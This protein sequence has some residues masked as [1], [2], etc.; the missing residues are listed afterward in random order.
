MAA[1]TPTGVKAGGGR[2][3]SRSLVASGAHSAG[4]AIS[5]Q[6]KVIDPSSS[7]LDVLKIAGV[8][9]IDAADGGTAVFVPK[10]GQVTVTNTLTYPRQIIAHTGGQWQYDDDITSGHQYVII[11]Y[12]I[13]ANTIVV[14]PKYT[15]EA[16]P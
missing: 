4:A 16:A 5:G 10:G 1:F 15:G 7:D 9:V 2:T 3:V 13:D 8:A 6:G 14:D 11:G 12:S